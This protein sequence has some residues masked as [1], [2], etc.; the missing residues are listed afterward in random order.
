[1]VRAVSVGNEMSCLFKERVESETVFAL[2]WG[3]LSKC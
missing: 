2:L 3:R 1:M